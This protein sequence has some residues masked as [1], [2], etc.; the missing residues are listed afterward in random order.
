M[1]HYSPVDLNMIEK[2][3]LGGAGTGDLPILT[4]S[5]FLKIYRV[6]L[7]TNSKLLTNNCSMWLCRF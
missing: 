1:R 7:S 4:N 3:D 2:L 5:T 6:N